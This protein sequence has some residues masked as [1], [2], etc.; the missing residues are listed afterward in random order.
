MTD[1]VLAAYR[2]KR[3]AQ[4]AV[5][6]KFTGRLKHFLKLFVYLNREAIDCRRVGRG[7][8]PVRNDDDGIS[9]PAT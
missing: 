4:F 8:R 9:T 5:V 1:G 7:S 2:A 3:S 6:S